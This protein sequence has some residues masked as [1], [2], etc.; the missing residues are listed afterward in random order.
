MRKFIKKNRQ[1]IDW[2]LWMFIMMMA[3]V[4]FWLNKQ[5]MCDTAKILLI[6]FIILI[7]IMLIIEIMVHRYLIRKGI[8]A[9]DRTTEC[10]G[11]IQP[12]Q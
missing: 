11:I 4:L 12:G 8:F 9:G 2:F 7:I 5:D 3:V 6:P 10:Q 1:T